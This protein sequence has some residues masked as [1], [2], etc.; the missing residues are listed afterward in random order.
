M[1][2]SS[3]RSSS[4]IK[5]RSV[6]H[7]TVSPETVIARARARATMEA[8]PA[9]KPL[10]HLPFPTIAPTTYSA[11]WSEL[12]TR[13]ETQEPSH[14]REVELPSSPPSSQE[15]SNNR[16]YPDVTTDRPSVESRT[17]IQLSSPVSN[18]DADS[19]FEVAS[20]TNRKVSS[21]QHRLRQGGLTSSV[22]KGEAATGLLELMRG[23]ASGDV[24]IARSGGIG[25]CGL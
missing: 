1:H 22:V 20:T 17:P 21:Q 13:N 3:P 6:S 25:M 14:D 15:G 2:S 19:E 7:T 8:K 24:R 4:T 23:G 11:R 5:A 10:S 9:V 12:T 16:T 18:P